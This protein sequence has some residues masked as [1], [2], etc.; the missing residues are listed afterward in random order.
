M[1]PVVRYFSGEKAESHLFVFLGIATIL[2][3]SYF[4]LGLKSSFWKGA[5]IPFVLVAVLELVVGFTISNR[6]PR[7][8]A[9]VEHQIKHEPGRIITEEIPRMEVV[10]RNFKVYRYVEIAL[11]VCGLILMYAG[12]IPSFWRGLGFGLFTQAGI[13]ICLDYF[14]EAR[15]V[16][17]LEYLRTFTSRS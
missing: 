14:A 7:D 8:I 6:S 4:L 15:G 3:A 17:Y 12:G 5:S 10:M 1:N 9:R 16:A 13:V 11:V 2:V